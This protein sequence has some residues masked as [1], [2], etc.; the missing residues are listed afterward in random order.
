M[1]TI[2]QLK[3][4]LLTDPGYVFQ[5]IYGINPDQ[6]IL[7]LRA[8]GFRISNVD[9]VMDAVDQ[10]YQRD[11]A[12]TLIHAF[13][14]PMLTDQIDPAEVIVAQEVAIA[15]NATTGSGGPKKKIDINSVLG[16]LA[17]G[18]TAY[19][20]IKGATNAAAAP[21]PAPPPKKDNTTTI[22]LIAG[23]AVV[24]IVIL[25]LVLKRE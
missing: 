9:D 21:T 15:L 12:D 11:E 17:A 24:L 16:A 6:V 3:D 4:R 20:G 5:Y 18:A 22:A 25:I 19:L 14:V 8:L 10:L 23:G 7:N 13:T 2:Q 1:Q